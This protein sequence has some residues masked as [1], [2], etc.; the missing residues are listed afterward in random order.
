MNVQ[1]LT[2]IEG[3][4]QMRE[5]PSADDA[6]VQRAASQHNRPATFDGVQC[7]GGVPGAPLHLAG[8]HTPGAAVVFSRCAE[9]SVG[10]P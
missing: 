6:L 2:T 1:L 7:G 8:D 9:A 10:S 4:C 5:C 3:S